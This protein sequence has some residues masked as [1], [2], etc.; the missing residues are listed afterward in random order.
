MEKA[1]PEMQ[2][3]QRQ[4]SKLAGMTQQMQHRLTPPLLLPLVLG[5][6]MV[7]MQQRMAASLT[8]RSSPTTTRR[9][10]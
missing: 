6:L 9:S 3:S 1:K 7:L 2:Q 5:L 4:V 8:W 10:Q